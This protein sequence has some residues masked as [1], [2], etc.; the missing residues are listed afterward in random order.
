MAAPQAVVSGQTMTLAQRLRSSGSDTTINVIMTEAP[1]FTSGI[2]KWGTGTGS[3][4]DA[5]TGISSVSGTTY[6]LTGVTRAIDK[7]ANSLT[8]NSA[9]NKKN[10]SVGTLG[11]YTL[12]SAQINKFVQKDADQ[13]ISGNNVNTGTN[14]YTS[15]T[16]TGLIVQNLT[17]AER[18]ALTGVANGAIIYNTTL[19]EFQVYQGG[20]WSSLASGSTQPDA[21]TTVAGKVELA[22]AAERAAGTST[23]GSGAAL[24]PTNDALVKT[25]SGA[26][27]EN[28][29]PILDSTGKFAVGFMPATSVSTPVISGIAGEDLVLGNAVYIKQSDSKLYKCDYT[30]VE[31][32]TV[33]G[34]MTAAALT[35]V[36]GYYQGQGTK[37]TTSGLTAGAAYYISVTAGAIATT[38]PAMNSASTIP[39]RIGTASSTTELVLNFQRLPRMIS[40]VTDLSG[41]VSNGAVTT[42]TL[43]IPIRMVDLINIASFNAGGVIQNVQGHGSFD[44]TVPNQKSVGTFLSTAGGSNVATSTSNIISFAFNNGSGQ[45]ASAVA[46]MDGSNNLTLTWTVSGGTPPSMIHTIAYERL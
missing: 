46:A 15:T 17:T 1:L 37:F 10:L 23:G 28:K 3:E 20:A 44:V 29:I 14:T 30:T 42:I 45:T 9:G 26:G 38:V 13:T 36:T 19:G 27:D 18:D 11:K 31:K 12:H 40:Q 8:D 35:G 4:W 5:F 25:S 32:A 6:Q 22:T 43:G 39:V 21:S 16:K 2:V 34:I 24:V 7:D 33:V 41:G